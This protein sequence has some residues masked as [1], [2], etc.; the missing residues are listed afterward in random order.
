MMEKIKNYFSDWTI[1]EKS[2]LLISAVVMVVLSIMWGDSAIALISGLS[3]V[4]SVVL[5]AKGKLSNYAFGLINALTYA[6]VSYQNRLYGEVMYNTIYMV[7]MIAI[8]VFTWKKNM[9]SENTEVKARNL[10]PKGWA[11][12]V[13]G[14]VAAVCV[15]QAIL[16]LMGGQM[17]WVDAMTTVFS[18]IATFLMVTRFSEQWVMWI[19]VNG[20]SIFLWATL[21]MQGGDA[22]MTTLVMWSA[23][24]FNSVY[25]YINWRKLAKTE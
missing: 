8:G 6:F 24:F 7:P 22:P 23:Y 12:L 11:M 15:Y 2:W 25:G 18:A 13:V 21:L 3:G 20:I 5:C 4:V 19:I 17:A 16:N 14:S 1:F 10:T 9:A